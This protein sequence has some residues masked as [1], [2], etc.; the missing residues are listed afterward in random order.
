MLPPVHSDY[1]NPCAIRRRSVA[2]LAWRW[3]SA[4]GDQRWLAVSRRAAGANPLALSRARTSPTD[5]FPG[6]K[7]A[8]YVRHDKWASYLAPESVCRGGEDAQAPD[9]EQETAMLCLIN[10]ARRHEG[11]NPLRSS[12]VLSSAASF[13]AR[14]IVRCRQF[15]HTACGRNARAVADE[16]GYPH[17]SWGENLYMSPGARGPPR[18]ALDRWLNS[19]HHRENLL[20]PAWTEQGHRSQGRQA[21]LVWL[22]LRGM[23]LRV[24]RGPDVIT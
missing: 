16:A 3:V 18:P 19:P 17:V 7:P 22:R 15:A 21:L 9:A 2:F 4:S 6:I 8:L 5:G 20:K 10:F 14:D 12:P 24:R 1:K 13:K 23:G 11:L